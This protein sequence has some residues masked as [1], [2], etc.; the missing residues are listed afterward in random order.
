MPSFAD[1]VLPLTPGQSLGSST[2]PWNVF[3]SQINVT[4]PTGLTVT[5]LTNNGS[6][7]VLGTATFSGAVDAGNENKILWVGSTLYPTC[8]AA[9]TAAGTVNKTIIA[10]RSDYSG[11]ACPSNYFAS[12][13]NVILWNLNG[14]IDPPGSAPGSGVSWNYSDGNVLA[15]QRNRFMAQTTPPNGAIVTGYFITTA[16][17]FNATTN[18]SNTID[19]MS[20]EAHTANTFTG[21]LPNLQSGEHNTTVSSTGGAVTNESGVTATVNTDVSS[22]TAVTNGRGVWAI[23]C[24]T[25]AAGNKPTNCYG[26]DASDQ[27]GKGGTRSYSIISRGRSIFGYSG[28]SGSGGFDAEDH[29]NVA[30]PLLTIDGS[31]NTIIQAISSAGTIFQDSGGANQLQITNSLGVT[32]FTKLSPRTAAA[33]DVGTTSLPFG[34]LWLGTAATNNFKFQPAATAAARVISMPDPLGAVNMPYAIANGTSTF[35]T[36]AVGAS[37]C[38]TTVTTAAT[39]ALTTD[40]IEIAYATAPAAATDSLLVLNMWVTSGNVNFSRCNPTAGSL[41]PTALVLNWRV[42]R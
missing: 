4:N 15:F 42:I 6:E 41:T 33:V 31:D 9:F 36:T 5:N 27:V 10:I 13:P 24:N 14:T 28:T 3:A 20:A 38:Q 1:N 37:A 17:G 7:T 30:H 18:T 40:S 29:L 19:G 12:N 11:A 32:P 26:L 35:T 23:G 16:D 39:G 21:T 2:L 8:Q 25:I 34:N 22:T